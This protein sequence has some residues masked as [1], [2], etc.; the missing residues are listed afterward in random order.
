MNE[1]TMKSLRVLCLE[2]QPRD[3]ELIAQ[4]LAAE[5]MDCEMFPATNRDEFETALVQPNID[6]ILCDFTLPSYGGAEA[7]ETAR[8]LLP[9]TPFIFVSGTIG[10]ER[11]V[12]GLRSG[13][14]DYVLKD[15]LERLVP[16]VNRA[17]R[18]VELRRTQKQA[19]EKLARLN[20][21]KEL[22]L[23]SAAEGILG[24]DLQGNH[25][26]VNPAAARM[27]GYEPQELIG[28]P[29]HS[30]WH[31][32]RADGS[33]YPSEECQIC[34]AYRDGV[35]HRVATEVFW[36]RDGTSFP[37]EYASTPIYEAGQ[38]AG[39]V[40]T[41]ADITERKALE[42]QLRQAQKIEAIGQLAGGVA[43]DFNN[44]LA[45]MRGNAEMLLAAAGQLPVATADGLNQIVAATER[46]ANLTRQLLVFS[47]KQVMQA[48][49]FN[50][51]DVVANLTRMLERIIGENI[52][53]QC[54]YAPDSPFIY[55]DAGMIEQVLVN[56]VINARDAM[57]H[58]GKVWLRTERVILEADYV[59]ARPEAR[60]GEFVRLCVRDNGAGIAPQ[61]LPRI[62]EPFFTTKE[63][64]KGTG[65]GL[66]IVYGIVKQH[67]GWIELRSQPGSGTR[68]EI[69]LP[70]IPA[71]VPAAGAPEADVPL[72]GGTERILLV[73]DD[74]DIRTMTQQL[75]KKFGYR[76][77][78]A[79]SAQEAL[80]I[81]R[82][83]ASEIDLLLT[84]NIMPGAGT[85]REL[86]EQLHQEN[87][88]LKII[89]IS[90]YSVDIGG[91]KA[92]FLDRM[93]GRFLQKPCPSR[94]M[95][96]TIR[97]CLDETAAPKAGKRKAQPATS[98]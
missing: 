80:D 40:V 95:L 31:H 89:F 94:T 87:P 81:W 90:G 33:P 28:C 48:Q 1:S 18:E 60:P 67:Q 25:T 44:L 47:R 64:G 12:E 38:I 54:D 36:R 22:I 68:F 97:T 19:E 77:W 65:L 39:A 84:D 27:L 75:L 83:H 63:P 30:T 74:A 43:H 85:G 8:K 73:E 20:Q 66:S 61:H 55:G 46:A 52:Q 53:L 93:G 26:F 79:G 24:L 5:G 13:A 29:S 3:R 21:H 70:A 58:G 51:N 23:R 9:D 56:L 59:R 45:V 41:F 49:A 50:L 7:L 42:D 91:G 34:A 35:V 15:H 88:Q 72:Q 71:P 17:L 11:A 32:T 2:D 76:V 86:A 14:T 78:E 16:V 82:A 10:E 62:F 4:A 57:S 98:G 37:V 96:E 92:D 6:L 69:L